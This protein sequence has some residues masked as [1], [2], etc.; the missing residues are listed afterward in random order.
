LNK[1][2][3]PKESDQKKAKTGAKTA[4]STQKERD[5]YKA[6][7]GKANQTDEHNKTVGELKDY[8]KKEEAKS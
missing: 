5:E 2:L 1:T 8:V 6:S 3:P 7:W 4:N